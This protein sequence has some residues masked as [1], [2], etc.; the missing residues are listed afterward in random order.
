MKANPEFAQEAEDAD[1]RREERAQ[2][3]AAASKRGFGA[4]LEALALLASLR[5]CWRWSSIICADVLTAQR[6]RFP[7]CR[8]ASPGATR[9]PSCCST[10]ITLLAA[11]WLLREGRHIRVDIV[12]RALPRRAAYAC[13]WIADAHR[14]RVCCL[15]L[16]V[17]RRPAALTSFKTAR[18]RSRRWSCP[19][20]G[21]SRRCRSASR[22]SRSS[23]CFACGG[24]RSRGRPARRRRERG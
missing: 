1:S 18:S 7:G 22:C 17:V 9:S 6:R 8:A 20:G 23:S 11:P 15:W 21:C 4:L 12:L 24:S 16:V 19:S 2:R 3:A 10:L 5:L 14:P 13:E